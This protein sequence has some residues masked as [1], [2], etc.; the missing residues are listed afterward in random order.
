VQGVLPEIRPECNHFSEKTAGL[1]LY[2]N[3]PKGDGKE[4]AS[5]AVVEWN[6]PAQLA[7]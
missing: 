1:R 5:G 6:V 3:E 2:R 4:G 7:S